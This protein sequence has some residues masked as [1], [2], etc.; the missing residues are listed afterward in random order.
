MYVTCLDRFE[1]LRDLGTNSP[2]YR[3][4]ALFIIFCQSAKSRRNHLAARSVLA[5][6]NPVVDEVH[7]ILRQRHVQLGS[8]HVL[9][10]TSWATRWCEIPRKRAASR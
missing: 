10:L 4:T 2:A 1:P 8:P 9:C 3:L 5:R 6:S 7:E